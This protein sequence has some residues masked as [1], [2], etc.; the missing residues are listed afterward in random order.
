[1][2]DLPRGARYSFRSPGLARDRALPEEFG[3]ITASGWR[4]S[5]NSRSGGLCGQVF[6]TLG[7]VELIEMEGE[8]LVLD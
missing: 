3:Q 8:A 2:R 5:S 4:Q 7:E 6:F 1:M